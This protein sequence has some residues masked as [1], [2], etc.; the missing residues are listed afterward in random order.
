VSFTI[1]RLCAFVWRL[2]SPACVFS[3][4]SAGDV[5]GRLLPMSSRVLSQCPSLRAR[6]KASVPSLRWRSG[7]AEGDGVSRVLHRACAVP[8][9]W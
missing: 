3:A 6:C 2:S 5:S 1:D 4:L 9:G 7:R 8:E